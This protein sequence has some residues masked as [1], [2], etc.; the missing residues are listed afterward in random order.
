MGV[1][2]FIKDKLELFTISGELELELNKIGFPDYEYKIYLTLV[3]V[4][5]GKM[6]E[7][8]KLSGVPYQKVY[9]VISMLERKGFVKVINKRPKRVK[10]ID[11]NISFEKY[12]QDIIEQIDRIQTKINNLFKENKRKGDQS[13]IIEGK[14]S[15]ITFLRNK[16]NEART[17]KVVY[18]GIPKWLVNILRRFNGELY[19][20]VKDEDMKKVKDLKGYIKFNNNVIARYIIF[21]DEISVIFTRTLYNC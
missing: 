9:D 10:L 7:I 5:E 16:I 6:S 3:K 21:D 15:V 14:R 18:P 4:C 2:I 12:K 13:T 17:V 1:S 11:P 8:S 19:L 20:V